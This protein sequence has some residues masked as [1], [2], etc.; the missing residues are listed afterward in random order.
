MVQIRV[1]T[2]VDYRTPRFPG[3]EEELAEVLSPTSTQQ[4]AQ[5]KEHG[6]ANVTRLHR[7][8][9]ASYVLEVEFSLRLHKQSKCDAGRRGCIR[10]QK[11]EAPAPRATISR[12]RWSTKLLKQWV[13]KL[14]VHSRNILH[15]WILCYLTVFAIGNEFPERAW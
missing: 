13:D 1:H 8:P 7:M 14:L 4:T 2:D 12:P 3:T 10:V 5:R 9:H 11:R 6:L 15:D